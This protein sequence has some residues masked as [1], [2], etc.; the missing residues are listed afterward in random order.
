MADYNS[1]MRQIQAQA[2]QHAASKVS[3]LLASGSIV[4]LTDGEGRTVG[5]WDPRRE[6]SVGID[7][8]RGDALIPL[9]QQYV[10]AN[11]ADPAAQQM[12]NDLTQM[13]AAAHKGDFGSFIHGLATRA[14]LTGGITGFGV[15]GMSLGQSWANSGLQ[16]GGP[17]LGEGVIGPPVPGGNFF[18][19]P[20]TP[21]LEPLNPNM[22]DL[23]GQALPGFDQLTPRG[24]P[25]VQ[26][27]PGTNGP[28]LPTVPGTTETILPNSFDPT[29]P[30]PSGLPP[31][32]NLPGQNKPLLPTTPG[33]TNTIIPGDGTAAAATAASGTSTLGNWLRSQGLNI[34]DEALKMMGAGASTLLGLY[35]AD[36][37]ASTLKD[38]ADRE[39]SIRQP[40]IDATKNMM[41]D[42]GSYY[43]SAPAKGATEAVLRR[44]SVNGNP[45]GNPGDLSKAAAYNLGGYNDSLRTLGG[46]AMGSAGTTVNLGRDIAAAEGSGLNAIGTTIADLTNPKED[47][48]AKIDRLLRMSRQPGSV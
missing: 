16:G 9:M 39:M 3:S 13:Q 47:T 43:E 17:M 6:Q 42:P 18:T 41:A 27:L 22:Y 12:Q 5:Y 28:L 11:P 21:A 25:P 44:L 37:Q 26:D 35:G 10:A 38:L 33:T 32:Q 7:Q 30:I 29:A 19:G 46:L 23:S 20:P 4:P 34:S 1:V 40:F 2:D 48:F 15:D 45:I 8:F 31:V 24:L 36:K 14:A